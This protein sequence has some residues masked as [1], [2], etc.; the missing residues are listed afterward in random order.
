MR[1][2]DERAADDLPPT[3]V[4]TLQVQV[5][6]LGDAGDFE[7]DRVVSI[8]R[9]RTSDV[10]VGQERVQGR[11]TV[12]K[13][14]LRLEWDGSRWSTLNVSDKAGL[15]RVYEPGYEE[16]PLESGRVWTPVRHRWSY[17]IGRPGSP[18]HVVCVTDDHRGPAG[19][20]GM[21][22][23]AQRRLAPGGGGLRRGAHGRSRGR[24]R[25]QP[26]AARARC[27]V[28]VLRRL[29]PAAETAHLGSSL[30]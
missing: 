21:S 25:P 3:A 11:W 8:G 26:D 15:L 29:R 23:A 12:S 7:R 5:L 6:P 9:G 20:A 22:A 18:F 14:H 17:S 13:N 4:M 24:P 1:T 16:V 10:C 28:R 30:A 27:L 2:D 19:I